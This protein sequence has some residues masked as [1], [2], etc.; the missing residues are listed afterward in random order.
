MMTCT[1]STDTRGSRITKCESGIYQELHY[2][3]RFF[4]KKVGVGIAGCQNV[5]LQRST[6]GIR[7]GNAIIS[8]CSLGSIGVFDRYSVSHWFGSRVITSIHTHVNSNMHVILNFHIIQFFY[9]SIFY[10]FW[11]FFSKTKFTVLVF[12]VLFCIY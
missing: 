7:P 10:L 11:H 12:L 2:P 6:N 8:S 3:L 9:H 4:F 1:V 5:V